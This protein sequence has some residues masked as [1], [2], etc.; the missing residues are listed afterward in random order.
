[1]ELILFIGLIIT[2]NAFS[3]ILIDF[4]DSI[5][6]REQ[7]V[8]I[9]LVATLIVNGFLTYKVLSIFIEGILE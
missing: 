2:I 5:S 6:N 8:G 9:V 7:T 4:A 1:M 3:V